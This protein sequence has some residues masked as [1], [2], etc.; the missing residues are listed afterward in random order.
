M[1]NPIELTFFLLLLSTSLYSQCPLEEAVDFK[2]VDINGD[3]IHLFELLESEH[4]YVLIDFFYADCGPCQNSAPSINEAFE[5]FGCGDFDVAFISISDRD[6]DSICHIFDET[7]GVRFTT[8]SGIEGGGTQIANQYE[9]QA[10][11]TVILIA[12]DLSIVE[13]DIYP[14][15]TAGHIINPLEIYEIEQNECIDDTID[16]QFMSDTNTICK[17][18]MIKF[19]NHSTGPIEQFE[20]YFE[21]GNP[22]TSTLEN[23][24]I[25]YTTAGTFDVKLLISNQYQTDT[26]WLDDHIRVEDCSGVGFIRPYKMNISPN[27]GNGVFKVTFPENGA[28]D[29]QVFDITGQEVFTTQLSTE[30]NQLDISHLNPGVYIIVTYHRNVQMKE[31][32]VVE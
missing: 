2:T 19:T 3:S 13:Q 20:W 21:G 7:Y 23:P 9:I 22:Q 25:L 14:I 26:L 10:F 1:R 12:P 17:G 5:Y 28:F 4:K 31:R 30:L 27:P 8:I 24:E 16:A 6:S 15:P 11:P 32:V 18:Q 29:V